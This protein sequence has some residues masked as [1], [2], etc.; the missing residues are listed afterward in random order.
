MGITETAPTKSAVN[1]LAAMSVTEMM[2]RLRAAR[3]RLA[4]LLVEQERL[5]GAMREIRN[6]LAG[7]Q[8][9]DGEA[10]RNGVLGTIRE[11]RDEIA[12]MNTTLAT[13]NQGIRECKAEVDTLDALRFRE[14]ELLEFAVSVYAERQAELNSLCAR[15]KSLRQEFE[16][17]NRSLATARSDLISARASKSRSMSLADISAA[18]GK[19][20]DAERRVSDA[21]L[22][23]GN[24][25][26]ALKR[27]PVEIEAARSALKLAEE[28]VWEAYYKLAVRDIQTLPGYTEIME[29]LKQAFVAW[30]A[31]GH[32]GDFGV[33]LVMATVGEGAEPPSHEYVAAHKAEL[34]ARL[35]LT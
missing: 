33:F 20:T 9:T 28:K 18:G 30:V 4:G 22:L 8:M 1:Q 7:H 15:A 27:L 23:V 10:S 31:S 14:E 12:S 35:K 26:S 25:N 6:W 24:L 19:E 5:Q 17:T 13:L 29:A 21:E 11:K 16:E 3:T 32:W 34:A 2:E